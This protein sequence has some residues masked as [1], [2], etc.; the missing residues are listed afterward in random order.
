MQFVD[1]SGQMPPVAVP[2][3]QGRYTAAQAPVGKVRA[4]IIAFAETGKMIQQYD[5]Q[6]PERVNL[7][8]PKHREGIFLD[9]PGNFG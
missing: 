9:L 2:I 6:V 1:I 7:V 5:A 4:I 8:P 3:V